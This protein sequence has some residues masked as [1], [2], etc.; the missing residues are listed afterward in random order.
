[1]TDSDNNKVK[2]HHLCMNALY[3]L[4]KLAKANDCGLLKEDVH[5]LLLYNSERDWKRLLFAAFLIDT[6]DYEVTPEQ[7]KI[8]E[9]VYDTL[10][11]LMTV[12]L[13]GDDVTNKVY[14]DLAALARSAGISISNGSMIPIDVSAACM[15]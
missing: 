2:L 13:K 8:V 3:K 7:L 1:M 11:I 4:E 5:A 9:G 15:N 6:E 10:T 12:N 14:N